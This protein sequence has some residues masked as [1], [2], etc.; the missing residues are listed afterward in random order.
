MRDQDIYRTIGNRLRARRRALDLTQRDVARA[1]GLTFQQIYKYEA[2]MVDIPIGRLV[3]LARVLETT[4][5]DLADGLHL[6]AGL[7]RDEARTVAA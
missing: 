6:G 2:G 1:L 3:K 7:R 5:S 4:L